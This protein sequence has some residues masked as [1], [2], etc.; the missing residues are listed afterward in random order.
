[1]TGDCY[2]C[3][4][5]GHRGDLCPNREYKPVSKVHSQADESIFRIYREAVEHFGDGAV[6]VELGNFQGGS[7]CYM[8][9]LIKNSGKDI[10]LYCVDLWENMIDINVE[11]SIFFEFWNNVYNCGFEQIIKPIQADSSRAAALFEDGS[12]DFVY[13]DGDHSYKGAARDIL[14]W[15]PK[16]KADG[17][18][19]GHDYNQEV[20]KVVADVFPEKPLV[21]PE[22]AKSFLF[23]E[24]KSLNRGVDYALEE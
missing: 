18:M 7:A 15:L 19:G 16:L 3:G 12:V 9:E 4:Q 13:I 8:A 21:Y 24:I 1:M 6:F 10:T 2:H 11:G 23:K 20:E 17:W 5:R 14:A 22:G